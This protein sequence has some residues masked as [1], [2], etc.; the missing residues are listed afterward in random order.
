MLELK[1]PVLIPGPQPL[2]TRDKGFG[3]F[4]TVNS[5]SGRFDENVASTKISPVRII[6]AKIG[7]IWSS[8]FGVA[9]KPAPSF[10]WYSGGTLSHFNR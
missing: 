2:I 9:G 3:N 10:S 4:D 6:R 5:A 7:I 1:N 8:D